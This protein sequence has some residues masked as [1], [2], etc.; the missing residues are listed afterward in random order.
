VVVRHGHGSQH[1][2]GLIPDRSGDL[3]GLFDTPQQD[4]SK[5]SAPSDR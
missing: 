3:L 4:L 1:V 2:R 5:K